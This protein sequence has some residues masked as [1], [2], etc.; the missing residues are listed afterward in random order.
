MSFELFVFRKKECDPKRC[1]ALKLARLKVVTLLHSFKRISKNTILLN[2][3]AKIALSPA[4]SRF[5][6]ITALDC[7]WKRAK[8]IFS[9][10]RSR[11][12][13]RALPYLLAS[14]PLNYGKP[15]KLSTAEA[16]TSAL[17]ILGER[18]KALNIIQGFSWEKAFLSLNLAMLESYSKAK[19]SREIIELQSAFM[20]C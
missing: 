12:N 20:R 1:T 5:R 8:E 13:S 17:F 19:D 18:E 14:N 3:F 7:S 6:T 4:D 16:L 10:L 11:T 9:K 2:P 15:A